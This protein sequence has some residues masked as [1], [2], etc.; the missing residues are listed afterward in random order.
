ML[1]K[2]SLDCNDKK[3]ITFLMQKA[4]WWNWSFS[5]THSTDLQDNKKVYPVQCFFSLQFTK[6][7]PDGLHL[8]EIR[9]IAII[10]M[11]MAFTHFLTRKSM[12]KATEISLLW[13]RTVVRHTWQSPI[14]RFLVIVC[15]VKTRGKILPVW[16]DISLF[17]KKRSKVH[18]QKQIDIIIL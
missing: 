6:G 16:L 4:N 1:K 11:A 2:H 9:H 5:A 12:D 14:I 15:K 18:W 8:Q 7:H 3:C 10:L 17:L 13:S